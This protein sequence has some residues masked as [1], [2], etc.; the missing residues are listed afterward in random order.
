MQKPPTTLYRKIDYG[1]PVAAAKLARENKVPTFI[2][3]SSLGANPGSRVFYSR[4]KGQM[5]AAV[6]EAGVSRTYILR[7]SVIAGKR[8][9]VRPG[10][11]VI[12]QL[13][14]A[15]NVVLAGP[16]ARYRS[17]SPEDIA[18]C[19]IWLANHAYATTLIPSDEIR[20]IAQKSMHR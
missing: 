14:K 2:V 13:M 4:T 20:E 12:R 19:M 1:I 5:E 3:M 11:W 9:E 18:R 8:G 16:L 17:I 15:L 10:E 6:C 7:P